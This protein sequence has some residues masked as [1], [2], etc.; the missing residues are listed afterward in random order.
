M[1]H[2]TPPNHGHLL[3]FNQQ[4]LDQALALVAAHALPE[5]PRLAGTVGAHLRHV[6][7]HYDALVFPAQ[8]G[9]VDYDG[10][11]R[12]RS[13]ETQPAVATRRLMALR[14]ELSRWP[15]STLDAAVKVLGIAGTAGE[16]G[17]AAPSS[18]ARE[19]AF[20]ASHAVHHF[21]LL[22]THCQHNGT[23]LP[24]HFGKAPATVAHER[25][26]IT[27][28]EPCPTLLQTA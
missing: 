14:S 28:E 26:L 25:S 11:A 9:V 17:F 18:L 6:I 19:L 10:R 20:V 4:V 21:A 1:L 5:G 27:K 2:A 3:A 24:A 16:F 13:L 7:E 23:P 8:P 15:A 22:S 12:E